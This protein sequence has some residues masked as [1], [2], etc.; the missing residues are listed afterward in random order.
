[1]DMCRVYN[2]YKIHQNAFDNCHLLQHHTGQLV[3]IPQAAI[4][5]CRLLQTLTNNLEVVNN[6]WSKFFTT[7]PWYPFAR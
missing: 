5:L 7:T 3:M 2:N 1:M 4:V 6:L